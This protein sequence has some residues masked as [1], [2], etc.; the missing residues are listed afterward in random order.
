[1]KNF[2]LLLILM[3]IELELYSQSVS[4]PLELPNFII[5]GKEQID[6]QVGSKQVPLL[7]TYL[8]RNTIDSLVI[9]G[10][11]RNYIVFPVKIPNSI[12]AK[13][14]PSGYVDGN[15]GSFLTTNITAGYKTYFKDYEVSAFGN[16]GASSGH[17]E[18]ANYAKLALGLQT[19][20]IAP[21]KYYIFGNSKTTTNVDLNFKAYKLYALTEAPKRNQIDLSAKIVSVGDFEGYD[22]QTGGR[23]YTLNLSGSDKNFAENLLGGFLE[24]KNKMH[25]NN[26]GGKL[27]VD[28]RS[29]DSK[30]T[31]F[32]Q[33]QGNASFETGNFQLEPRLGFQL[34]NTS[35]SKTRA[36]VLVDIVAK[37]NIN[38]KI[39]LWA[40]FANGL[41]NKGLRDFLAINPY[42]SDS[43]ALDF[44][45]L[46]VVQAKLRYQPNKDLSIVLAPTFSLNSRFPV[47]N[48]VRLGYFDIYYVDATIF[49][50]SFEGYWVEEKIGTVSAAISL[51][52]TKQISNKKN[53]PT[54]PS[55]QFRIDCFKEFWNKVKFVGFFEHFG[56]R[57]ADLES[58]LVLSSYNNLGLGIE[59]I[60]NRFTILTFNAENLLNSNIVQWYGYKEWGLN[61]RVGLVYIF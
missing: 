17:I 46:T 12:I 48:S 53:I 50:L 41:E 36:M 56:K 42:I 44:C 31:N 32:F 18:N 38:E 37:T 11:P 26:L 7:Q 28:F 24:V 40:K 29:T 15:I 52:T 35:I 33:L 30:S 6:V 47:L 8:A 23:F 49:T 22:F 14:F 55:L 61:L 13:T 2:L 43:F 45:N 34:A 60:I 1:M 25:S 59:Y 57:Y 4:Q 20:Y 10:K 19:D 27:S 51:N 54:I 3:F 16:F 5:E 9:V 58:S 39:T 21:D